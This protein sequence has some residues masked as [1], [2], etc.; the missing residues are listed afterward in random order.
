MNNYLEI[1]SQFLAEA[2]KELAQAK[3]NGNDIIIRDAAEKA[4]NA[5]VQATNGLFLA[6]TKETPQSH[7]ERRKGLLELAKNF[8][9]IKK[10]GLLD[11]FMARCGILHENCFYEGIYDLSLL[12]EEMEKVAQYIKDVE[13]FI[14]LS[15]RDV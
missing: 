2:K 13:D 1:A 14:K 3:Q 15:F 7:Y 12:E 8:P 10:K 11:R 9:S 4:W 5:I 6:K